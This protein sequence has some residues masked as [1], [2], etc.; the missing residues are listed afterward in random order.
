MSNAY[1]SR[2]LTLQVR[3]GRDADEFFAFFPGPLQGSN[4]GGDKIGFFVT[5]KQKFHF[6]S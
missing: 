5:P 6:T 1:M 2:A 4:V 3:A